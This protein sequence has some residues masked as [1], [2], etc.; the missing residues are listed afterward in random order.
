MRF[1]LEYLTFFKAKKHTV[2]GF[3]RY[4]TYLETKFF[5]DRINLRNIII[6]R[7]II[8]SLHAFCLYTQWLRCC[9]STQKNWKTTKIQYPN[10]S[11]NW[12][13]SCMCH[14]VIPHNIWGRV[15]IF[16]L[17]IYLVLILNRSHCVCQTAAT[18]SHCQH[19][20]EG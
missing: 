10:T 11:G 17:L 20:Q 18:A 13:F 16:A 19:S 8:N 4:C 9:I 12:S 6:I 5:W 7:S 2:T 15:S 3:Q 14:L 1:S